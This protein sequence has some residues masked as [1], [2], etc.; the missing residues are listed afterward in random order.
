MDSRISWNIL[1]L[2]GHIGWGG[3]L[4]AKHQKPFHGSSEEQMLTTR[5]NQLQDLRTRLRG[6]REEAIALRDGVSEA[7]Y[8]FYYL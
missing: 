4:A 1:N 7:L 5:L 6:L 2:E 8:S 3:K